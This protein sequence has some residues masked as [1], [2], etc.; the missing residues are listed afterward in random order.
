MGLLLFEHI[1]A[2]E[3]ARSAAVGIENLSTLSAPSFPLTE[4]SSYGR[5]N[6][7]YGLFPQALVRMVDTPDHFL[8]WRMGALLAWPEYG[9]VDAVLSALRRGR[10][11]N[12]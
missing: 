1:I 5:F 4:V 7:A 10:S 6:N 8:T 12:R 2:F 9:V 3:S 11:S